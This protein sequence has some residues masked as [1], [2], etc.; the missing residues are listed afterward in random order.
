MSSSCGITERLQCERSRKVRTSLRNCSGCL[1]WTRCPAWIV[2]RRACG[3]RWASSATCSWG[4]GLSGPPATTSVGTLIV[5]LRAD[6]AHDLPVESKLALGLGGHGRFARVQ[7]GDILENQPPQCGWPLRG[8][9]ARNQ[10]AEGVTN[11]VDRR[12]R[13]TVEDTQHVVGEPVKRVVTRP[14]TVPVPTQIHRVDRPV[15][16]QAGCHDIPVIGRLPSRAASIQEA[17]RPPG[18]ATSAT[19]RGPRLL[20]GVWSQA[21]PHPRSSRVR[22]LGRVNA[23]SEVSRRVLYADQAAQQMAGA[24]GTH[25]DAGPVL[26]PCQRRPPVSWPESWR[27]VD[28]RRP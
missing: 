10:T 4:I 28:R 5:D 27:T 14:I 17:S 19:R 15:R 6:L 13:K 25:V 21:P 3:T 23:P 11:E 1:A 18:Q 22:Q 8:H 7:Q 26:R 16:A 12:V 2:V 20:S 9:Q 24:T